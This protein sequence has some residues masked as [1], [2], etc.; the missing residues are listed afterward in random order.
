MSV[1]VRKTIAAAVAVILV[2]GCAAMADQDAIDIERRLSAAGFQMKLANT[3]E[4]QAH[5]SRFAQRRLVP[6][7]KEG[8]TVF[9][10]ADAR[11][12]NCIYVGS[13]ANYQEY[14]RLSI[15]QHVVNE[16]RDTAEDMNM[17]VTDETMNWDMWG[18]WPRPILY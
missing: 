11:E 18:A 10:Y 5:L 6:M 8:A 15:Q 9:V 2:G 17:A 14:Q 12:C 13:E 16:Q 4:K 7:E 3:P 1:N